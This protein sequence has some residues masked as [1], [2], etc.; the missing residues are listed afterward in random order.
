MK[1][2]INEQIALRAAYVQLDGTGEGA[3]RVP[4]KLGTSRRAVAK[5]LAA[6]TRALEIFNKAQR[7]LLNEKFPDHPHGMEIMRDDDPATF[8]AYTSQINEIMAVKEEIELEPIAASVLYADG[9]EIGAVAL[10]TL[11]LHG[12]VSGEIAGPP[13]SLV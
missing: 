4:Y 5:N 13:L 3:G 12:L 2:N 6:L 8:D 7:S 10:A 11:E 1:L 9:N